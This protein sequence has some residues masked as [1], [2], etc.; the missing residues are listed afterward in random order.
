MIILEKPFSNEEFVRV[1]SIE[2]IK[3]TKPNETLIFKYCD[4]S[5]EV[6]NFCKINS[7]PYAVEISN[8]KELIFISNLNAKYA[9]C[10]DLATAKKLQEVAENYLLDTKIIYLA[11]SLDEIEKVASYS[12]DGIKI[13]K[14]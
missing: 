1:N 7:I 12:I 6:Y 14:S 4:S 8:I 9:F 2:D 10:K 5:L 13:E 11:K 3:K